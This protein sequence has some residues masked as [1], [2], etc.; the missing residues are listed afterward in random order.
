[1][2]RTD[3]PRRSTDAA[4]ALAAIEFHRVLEHVA[5]FAATDRGRDAVLAMAPA[6]EA[7]EAKL[8]L[9]AVAETRDFLSRKPAWDVP[10]FA[11]PGDALKRLALEGSA[12]SGADLARIS[13]LLNASGELRRA[14]SEEARQLP[15][16]DALRQ[17]LFVDDGLRRELARA[18]G[19]DGRVLD[20]ASKPLAR[21]R[22][23][24][25]GAHKRVVAHLESVLAGLPERHRV[26]DA[27]VSV[28]DGRFVIPVRREGKRTVGG[29]VHDESASGATVFVEPP[30]AI[31]MTNAVRETERAERRE[32]E[33]ILRALAE[34]C[35]PCCRALGA[36]LAA[37]VEMDRRVALARA[38]DAW[39]G[40]VP[41]VASGSPLTIRQGRHPLLAAAGA[42]PV[43]FD[44]DLPAE[45]AVVVVTGPNAGGKTVFL[46]SVGLI[47]SLAQS[48]VVP[49]VG[50][51]TRLPAFRS[52]F[53]DI[54]DQ[55]S[56]SDHLSTFSAH[57]ANLRG[58]LEGADGHA[59][60][61]V[62]EPG[63]GTDPG[64]GE[65]LA[66]AVVETLAERGCMAVVTS[67]MS[68]LKRLAAPGNRIANAS[69]EFDA[70]R[71]EPTFRFLWGRPGRSFGLAMARGLGFPAAVLDRAARCRDETEAGLD[72][73][74][75][76]LER[77]ERRAARKAEQ[78]EAERERVHA[79][80]GELERREAAL[81]EATETRLAE[82]RAQARGLLLD[83]RREVEDAIAALQDRVGRSRALD[84]AAREARQAVERA[85][86]RTQDDGKRAAPAPAPSRGG[87]HPEPGQWVAVAGSSARGRVL[88]V[89]GGRAVVDAAGL[90]MTV[91]LDRLRA[92][93]AGPG[94]PAE[95]PAAPGRTT[96]RRDDKGWRIGAASEE[97]PVPSRTRTRPAFGRRFPGGD[98]DGTFRSAPSP[99]IDL[100]GRRADEA[101]AALVK[102][103]DDASAADL[104]LL[105]V[106]HGKGTGALRERVAEVLDGGPRVEEFRLGQPGE[107]G[108]GVTVARVG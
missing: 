93:E 97:P 39:N 34:R 69:M 82:A 50:P 68:G 73:L 74:L 33:R 60:V 41:E 66:R 24:L 6:G 108:G 45:G 78:L 77:K 63:A 102:A 8:R 49:P 87:G 44:V 106:I 61:L 84:A 92:S 95:R 1:M 47:A 22:S 40:H 94:G 11:D 62:D 12:L 4:R 36:S 7:R 43:P 90:R 75:S 64:E 101:E 89:E 13:G 56:I 26:P 48:G 51:G 91:P 37:L 72:D 42:G 76:S 105:R 3:E 55:Q 83:A 54:G 23:R 2:A 18:I 59:L 14:L 20:A 67:H 86:A 21:L 30:S 29:Y 27:S 25:V 38:A 81:A 19:E 35:R 79:L 99:E 71:L 100:R 5:S 16:L 98:I 107:G 53:A 85:A 17:D 46:K 57:L 10:P 32:V 70:E 65:A 88:A 103:L 31:A 9:D 28:R 58:V 80:R 96:T 15:G 52:F 104:R